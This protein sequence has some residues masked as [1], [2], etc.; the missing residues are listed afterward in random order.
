M[1]LEPIFLMDLDVH[2]ADGSLTDRIVAVG[3]LSQNKVSGLPTALSDLASDIAA[4]ESRALAAEGVLAGDIAAE[5]A[6]ALAA[7]GVLAGDIAAEEARALAA[8]GVLSGDI[9]AE[10]AARIAAVAA[11]QADVDGIETAANAA[12]VAEEARALA[13]EAVLQGNIDL[14]FD[15]AGGAID[16]DG[17]IVLS[18]STSD[19]QVSLAAEQ[20]IFEGYNGSVQSLS[21]FNS[22]VEFSINDTSSSE[23]T[24][25]QVEMG[26]ISMSC[27]SANSQVATEMQIAQDGV[28]LTD[29]SGSPAMPTLDEHVVVKKYVDDEVSAAGQALQ[30][31]IDA[32]QAARIAGD[33]ATLSSAEAY[34]DTKVAQ[35]VDSAPALLDT[36][37][38]LAAALGDD[39][40]FSTTVLNAI[41]SEQTR[42]EGAEAALDGRLDV[43]EAKQW[44]QA[45]LL[46]NSFNVTSLAKP[47]GAPAIPNSGAEVQVFIDGRKVFFG[48]QFE[49]A[50]G[51]GSITF[52]SL[53]NNQ[54]V[55]LL[56]WA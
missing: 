27:V 6:R 48:A 24:L 47:V 17:S 40:N 20:V 26:S 42:A 19:N 5:E 11:V 44:R 10:T 22:S 13:A 25:M 49:V 9:A 16:P 35:L 54:T 55:E 52:P 30:G 7:E 38:E 3:A 43:I 34:T 39:P 14:K 15:K 53:K 33:A 56:Y 4:E 29:G 28:T 37:N 50:V 18:S 46:T 12:V 41:S 31:N 23:Q 2:A 51:G 32:E 21:T 1:P 36:L 8:E 45:L